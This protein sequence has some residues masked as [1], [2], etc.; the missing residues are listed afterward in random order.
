MFRSRETCER[1]QM[2]FRIPP[3]RLS[4]P[5]TKRPQV[6]AAVGAEEEDCCENSIR[7]RPSGDGWTLPILRRSERLSFNLT[8]AI[9]CRIHT[10]HQKSPTSSPTSSTM[11][12]KRSDNVVL[13]PNH[14]F[15]AHENSFSVRYGSTV[16]LT[17]TS[18]GRL[19]RILPTH[20]VTTPAR[21]ILLV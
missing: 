8:K 4:A 1:G 3:P 16:P 14:G 13:F 11:N 2:S 6:V 17:S 21:C 19:F 15:R 10:S 9:T 5:L 7:N 20:P 12:H 18:G